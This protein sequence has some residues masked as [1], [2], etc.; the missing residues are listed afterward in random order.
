MRAFLAE[1]LSRIELPKHIAFI[2]EEIPKTAVGKPDW[3]SLQEREA[4]KYVSYGEPEAMLHDLDND[5][6]DME[7]VS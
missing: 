1:H 2:D 5:D 3:R 4:L 6:L 7:Q